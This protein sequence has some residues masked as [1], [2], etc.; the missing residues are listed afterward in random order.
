MRLPRGTKDTNFTLLFC[1]CCFLLLLFWLFAF[2]SAPS[3]P[4]GHVA[5]VAVVRPLRVRRFV[6][7]AAPPGVQ[8]VRTPQVLPAQ[9]AAGRLLHVLGT[10][11]L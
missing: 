3:P 4:P 8:R 6:Q 7:Q 5:E 9:A 1:L 10:Q 11:N 2:T